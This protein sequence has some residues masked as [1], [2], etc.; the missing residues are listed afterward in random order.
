MAERQLI[1]RGDAPRQSGPDVL[2]IFLLRAITDGPGGSI[3]AQSF[4]LRPRHQAQ[5]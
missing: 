2:A 4:G 3:R 1:A 5:S